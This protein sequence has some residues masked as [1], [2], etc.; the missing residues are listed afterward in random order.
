[1]DIEDFE[2]VKTIDDN[3]KVLK[4]SDGGY[5]FY[6]ELSVYNLS[7]FQWLKQ[8]PCMYIPE[9]YDYQ[10]ID[11]KLSVLEEYIDGE[12]LETKLT[13]LTVNEKYMVLF[14]LLEGVS[15]LHH[16]SPSIIHRDIKPSN[17][18][19]TND[20]SVK[21]IDYD[22]AKLFVKNEPRDTVLLGTEGSAAPEQYGFGSSDQRTDI[23]GIGILI[24]EMFPD[25]MKML[26]IANKCTELKP[27][28][29]YQTVDEL[30]DVIK[31]P[32]NKPKINIPGFRTG[33]GFHMILAIFGYPFLIYLAFHSN[34]TK[35]GVEI[36][37]PVVV[38]IYKWLY[39]FLFACVLDLFTHWSGFFDHFLFIKS[40]H[41]FL[42]IIGYCL[43]V[44]VILMAVGFIGLIIDDIFL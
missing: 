8:H 20:G 40:K 44:I 14:Q 9:I 19:I 3:K 12:T 41:W 33:N 25:Q 7:V 35:D 34:A 10:E 36:T 5:C 17:I 38:A 22:A 37:K 42:R 4:D 6:K 11:G 24:R 30:K 32:Q 1:M 23:Y 15:Y 43:A 27:D 31:F 39:V 28:D 2:I 13:A 21:I 18:M 26:Q 16:A 29:R